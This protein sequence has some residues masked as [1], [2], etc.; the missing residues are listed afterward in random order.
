MDSIEE[1]RTKVAA[2]GAKFWAISYMGGFPVFR[3]SKD[4]QY[5]IQGYALPWGIVCSIPK[6][7]AEACQTV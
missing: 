7:E 6:E 3:D 2:L 4:K 1:A 5:S